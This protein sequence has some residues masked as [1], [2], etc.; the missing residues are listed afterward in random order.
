M[1]GSEDKTVRIWDIE[2]GNVE[3][4]IH[5]P[6][7]VWNVRYDSKAKNIL[8]ACEDYKFR[9]LTKNS[10]RVAD[11]KELKEFEE[12]GNQAV[13]GAQAMD[14]NS[15]PLA[16]EMHRHPGGK[17]GQIK[18]FNN[19][20]VP[21]AYEWQAANRQWKLIGEVVTQQGAAGAGAGDGIGMQGRVYDG[22]KYF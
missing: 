2:S 12:S 8:T 22:D 21:C 4:I 13:M 1:T 15:L 16:S 11:E 10:D 6:A 7:T 20:G 9:V 18:V 14:V 5:H 19:K 17:N 3:Q